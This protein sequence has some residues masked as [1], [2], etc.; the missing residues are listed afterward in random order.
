MIPGP[1]GLVGSGEFTPA[2]HDVDADLLDHVEEQGFERAVAVVPTAAAT[3]GDE[4]VQRWFDMA[5]QHFG[6]MDAEVLRVDVRDRHDAMQL[7]HV[8]DV[9]EVGFVYFSGGKPDHLTETIRATPLWDAVTEQWRL[10][11]AV[12]GCS[13][14]A[15]MLAAGWPPFLS[16]QGPWGR[17]MGVVPGVAVVPHF[18]LV[19]RMTRGAID[20]AARAAPDGQRVIGVDEDTAL[21][22]GPDG[23][24]SSGVGEVWE[25]HADGP[26]PLDPATLPTPG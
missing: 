9:G 12:V 11:G 20:K 26:Q 7:A 19:R 15:M 16:V 8:A 14:G 2:M 23:W 25:L 3:E 6:A 21:V 22:H 4:V 13:A 1:I 10:G 5:E 17:G 24:R 18:D